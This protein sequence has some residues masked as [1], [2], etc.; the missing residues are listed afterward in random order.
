MFGQ[1]Y[2]AVAPWI[3]RLAL[4]SSSHRR[5]TFAKMYLQWG[6]CASVGILFIMETTPLFKKSIFSKLPVVGWY[7]QQKLDEAA[8]VD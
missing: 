4:Y 3:R 6:L 2:I 1:R 8:R 7:W 5:K